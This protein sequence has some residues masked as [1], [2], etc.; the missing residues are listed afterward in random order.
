VVRTLRRQL[1]TLRAPLPFGSARR[2]EQLFATLRPMLPRRRSRTV[3]IFTT[4]PDAKL[5]ALLHRFFAVDHV[6]MATPGPNPTAS[7]SAGGAAY[8]HL[9]VDSLAAAH[10]A[11]VDVGPVDVL[12]LLRSEWPDDPAA[13]LRRL[14]FHLRR[15]G[16]Y[17]VDRRAVA[18]D[19]T[20][21]SL[22]DVVSR[23][24][25]TH[26]HHPQ[27]P[28]SR[29]DSELARAVGEVALTSTLTAM[30]TT[31]DHHLKLHDHEA[32]EV[33][34]RRRGVTMSVF[35][36]RPG[37]S[38]R[39]RARVHH[40][41]AARPPA[42]FDAVINYPPLSARSYGGTIA[43]AGNSLLF[44]D[45]VLLP[46]SFR[47]YLS[48]ALVNPKLAS[49]GQ[50]FAHV[51]R[52]LHPS[53]TL[54]GPYFH[55]DSAYPGHF[56]HAMTEVV[57]RLWAWDQA[58]GLCPDLRAVYRSGRS[59][60]ERALLTGFGIAAD[61]IV[62]VEQPVYLRTVFSATPMWHNQRPHAVHPEL[63]R[64]WLRLRERLA[65]TP[66]GH[67][68]IFVS[69]PPDVPNRPCANTADVERHFASRGFTV[70][71]PERHPLA[72][73]ASLFAGAEVVAGFAG[74]GL[75][76]VLF[77]SR[78]KTLIILLHEAYTARNEYLYASLLGCELHYL[79]SQPDVAHPSGRWTSEA[80]Q[81]AWTF[82]LDRHRR[83][84][85]HIL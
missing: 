18:T 1:R 30:S 34:R 81:S 68:K 35:D 76:N 45:H 64:V 44:T 60:A 23:L 14:F 48:P 63:E 57:A 78:L 16:V 32:E 66:G 61:D 39:S 82:D 22:Q 49:T 15:G 7:P 38:F 12:L 80:F 55:L 28:L 42:S 24:G 29:T 72:E 79:W 73:Q 47:Y 37:G 33:L 6:F 4:R 43:M 8:E 59:E 62:A 84:L 19:A 25:R 41:G 50:P 58:K 10:S 52:K 21:R 77:S 17:A 75:F 74:S 20:W 67:R 65:P 2:S 53:S 54:P 56:G 11:L 40:H 26:G 51:P 5:S 9:G 83:T 31:R 13:T 85:D 3:V 69:R 71:Y 27:P 36:R 46:E 70:V